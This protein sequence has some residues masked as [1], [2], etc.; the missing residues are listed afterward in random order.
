MSFTGSKLTFEL[1]TT[2]QIPCDR[3]YIAKMNTLL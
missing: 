3:K 2:R 1:T